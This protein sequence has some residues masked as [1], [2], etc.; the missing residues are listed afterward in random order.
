MKA[1]RAKVIRDRP[2]LW[3]WV[4][5]EGVGSAAPARKGIRM[6]FMLLRLTTRPDKGKAQRIV[7]NSGSNTAFQVYEVSNLLAMASNLTAMASNQIHFCF[8]FYWF[9]FGELGVALARFQHFQT[10]LALAIGNQRICTI[11]YLTQGFVSLKEWPDNDDRDVVDMWS[12]L[13]L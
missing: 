6:S 3:G 11:L 7:C 12:T 5:S 10:A 2:A 1:T 9:R 4:L 13:L 8:F